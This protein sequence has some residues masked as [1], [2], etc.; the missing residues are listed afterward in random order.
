MLKLNRGFL[1]TL[2]IVLSTNT[3]K[4]QDAQPE[5][6]YGTVEGLVKLTFTNTKGL[7]EDV[8]RDFSETVIFLEP[9]GHE[10]EA[11]I[12]KQHSTIRQKGAKFIPSLLVIPKGQTVD[13]I[14]DDNIYHNA[15]SFS[16]T[17]EFDLGLYKSEESKSVTFNKAGF[18]EIFCSIHRNMQCTIYVS[19]NHL[20]CTAEKDGGFK[21]DNIPVGKYILKTWHRKLPEG[22]ENIEITKINVESKKSVNVIIDLNSNTNTK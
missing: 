7:K 13:F 21:L 9:N 19:P 11:I 15:F 1:F 10:V 3:I 16:K 18:V 17:K 5:H 14:N 4:T 2:I 6:K 20:F 12:S 8:K 22:V